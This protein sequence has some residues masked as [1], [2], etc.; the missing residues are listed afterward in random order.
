MNACQT[1]AVCSDNPSGLIVAE[2]AAEL[3]AAAVTGDCA[4][5]EAILLGLVTPGDGGSG[6]FYWDETSALPDDG[7]NVLVST[8][9]GAWIKHS[10]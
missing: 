6:K 9:A 5:V 10:A 2:T 3:R 7:V 1:T 8:T 4:A